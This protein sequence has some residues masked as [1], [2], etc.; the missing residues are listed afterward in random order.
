M[1][2][3]IKNEI[4]SNFNDKILVI[5]QQDFNI[6]ESLYK[7]ILYIKSD[8]MTGKSSAIRRFMIAN[9]KLKFL[10]IVNRIT[11]SYEFEAK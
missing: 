5:N 9:P 4:I 2:E 3:C 7:N 6:D 10:Y 8:V 1:R 11:Q